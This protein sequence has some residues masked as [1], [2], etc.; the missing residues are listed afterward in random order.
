MIKEV[1]IV[2]GRDDESAVKRALECEVI[3]TR[4]YGISKSTLDL[5]EQ[6]YYRK[7]III[8]TDPDHAGEQIRKRLSQRFPKALHAYLPR[9]EAEKAGDI[10]IENAT[11]ES[12]LRALSKVR[13]TKKEDRPLFSSED[14]AACGLVGTDNASVLRDRMGSALGIGYGNAKVFLKRLNHYDITKEEFI[15]AWTSCTHRRP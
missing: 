15:E 1:I 2:E 3:I 4:G 11:S 5:I 7:G 13:T 9:Q 10:G 6:A 14:M 12:I 8:F